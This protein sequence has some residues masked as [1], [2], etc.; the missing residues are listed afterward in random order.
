[1]SGKK[2]AFRAVLSL[3]EDANAKLDLLSMAVGKSKAAA[4]GD[5]LHIYHW[6]VTNVIKGNE[7]SIKYRDG[8]TKTLAILPKDVVPKGEA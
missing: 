7:F 1:M 3:K 2:V 8:T 6:L 4:L 5:A